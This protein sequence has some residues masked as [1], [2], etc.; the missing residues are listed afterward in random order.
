MII[1]S[2]SSSTFFYTIRGNENLLLLQTDRPNPADLKTE[3]GRRRLAANLTTK[4]EALLI[5]GQYFTPGRGRRSL[6]WPLFLLAR[7]AAS[8]RWCLEAWLRLKCSI[9]AQK[10]QQRLEREYINAIKSDAAICTDSSDVTERA[11]PH[12]GSVDG[13]QNANRKEKKN[14]RRSRRRDWSE[15]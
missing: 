10:H 13:A 5:L 9:W 1:S 4:N 8:N 2:S 11:A 6:P 14:I 7:E 15:I 3:H 12:A